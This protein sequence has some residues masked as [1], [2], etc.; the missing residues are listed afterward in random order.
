M[1]RTRGQIIDELKRVRLLLLE[2]K[3]KDLEMLSAKIDELLD[4]RLEQRKAH[5]PECGCHECLRHVSDV[6]ARRALDPS[7]ASAEEFG[8]YGIDPRR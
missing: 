7:I 2:T 8:R 3:E 1:P 4:E 5:P 6:L